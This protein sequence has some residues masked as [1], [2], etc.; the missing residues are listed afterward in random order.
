[1]FKKLFCLWH[2][3][4]WRNNTVTPKWQHLQ[5]KWKDF[6]CTYDLYDI[7]V[8]TPN[9][10][11]N[12]HKKNVIL[13][14]RAFVLYNLQYKVTILLSSGF[15]QYYIT[16]L[17]WHLKDNIHSTTSKTHHVNH[18][19]ILHPLCTLVPTQDTEFWLSQRNTG[20]KRKPASF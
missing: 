12:F 15:K 11:K 16:Y 2:L 8:C 18:V 13:S 14:L 3:M 20:I 1:M 4:A 7:A 9:L 5:C 17:S 6:C 19:E 10:N